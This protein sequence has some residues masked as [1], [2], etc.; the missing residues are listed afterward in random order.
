MTRAEFRSSHFLD[1]E[2]KD[3]PRKVGLLA[4]QPP[5][6]ALA[7]EYIIGPA[8]SCSHIPRCEHCATQELPVHRHARCWLPDVHNTRKPGHAHLAQCPGMRV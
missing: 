6:A 3:G 7:R 4:I 8:F 5:D 1:D 2:V